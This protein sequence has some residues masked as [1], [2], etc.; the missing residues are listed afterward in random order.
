MP[1]ERLSAVSFVNGAFQTSLTAEHYLMNFHQQINGRQ[2][3]SKPIT[4]FC[5]KTST[6]DDRP[7]GEILS[8]YD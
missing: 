2:L 8:L 3:A 7:A 1:I 5:D 4:A 6:V